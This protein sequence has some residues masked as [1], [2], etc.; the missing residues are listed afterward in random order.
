MVYRR[1]DEPIVVDIMNLKVAKGLTILKS[2]YI[3]T[4][5]AKISEVTDISNALEGIY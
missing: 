4:K 5:L 3:R 1:V 2:H